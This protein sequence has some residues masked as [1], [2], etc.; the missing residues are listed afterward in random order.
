MS[1][2]ALC[3]GRLTTAASDVERQGVEEKGFIKACNDPKYQVEKGK[4]ILSV[5]P[6]YFRPTE[7]DLLVG[8]PSK[9]KSKLKWEPEYDLKGLV[10]DMV[11]SDIKLMKKEQFLK[12]GGHKTLNYFE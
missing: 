4:E 11:H 8:D 3:G 1:G 12:Q 7:V 10:K 5:D 9:A 6:R 2:N